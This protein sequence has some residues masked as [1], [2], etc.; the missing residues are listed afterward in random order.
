MVPFVAAHESVP[1]PDRQFVA[2][3][4]NARN[5]GQSRRSVEAASTAAPDP[6]ETNVVAQCCNAIPTPWMQVSARY[7]RRRAATSMDFHR[8]ALQPQFADGANINR[9]EARIDEMR[10]GKPR[11]QAADRN[12][13]GGA[14]ENV[15]NA[16]MR[17]RTEG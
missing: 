7:D 13:D 4:Q 15:P 2:V 3:Q 8:K 11:Q 5:G 9:P 10:L 6:K 14:T 16:V 1:G 17:A 12:G